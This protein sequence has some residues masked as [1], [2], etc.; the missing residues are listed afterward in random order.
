MHRLK[1][2][3]NLSEPK[4][5]LSTAVITLDGWYQFKAKR[6]SKDLDLATLTLLPHV[7]THT[8][9]HTHNLLNMSHLT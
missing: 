9:I 3:F 2:T 4:E 7:H 1:C 5:L 6:P 8:H